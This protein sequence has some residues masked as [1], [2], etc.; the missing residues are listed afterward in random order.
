MP[1][2]YDLTPVA[3][4]VYAQREA[5]AGGCYTPEQPC[6]RPKTP[7]TASL[8]QRALASSGSTLL[9]NISQA[10][11]ISR[12]GSISQAGSLS[13]AGSD[14]QLQRLPAV[15]VEVPASKP[16]AAA[17]VTAGCLPLAQQSQAASARVLL[18]AEFGL[19]SSAMRPV[20]ASG[21]GMARPEESRA[22]SMG[23]L[24]FAHDA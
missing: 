1:D 3:Q 21:A 11:S 19:S 10:G 2:C 20:V 15:P 14:P 5:N 22:A 7:D 16:T 8:L 23:Q 12:A 13:Q 4:P 17:A 6:G 18:A 24:S 9:T